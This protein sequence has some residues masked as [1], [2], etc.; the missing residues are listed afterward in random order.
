VPAER[1]LKG[2]S[3]AVANVT[4]LLAKLLC[5]ILIAVYA[6][7]QRFAILG[8][9][10]GEEQPGVYEAVWREIARQKPE[11]IIGV[12]D[13][14]QGLDDSKAAS[15]WRE[16][17][18]LV[19]PYRR[20]PLYLAPGNHDIW[21]EASEKLYQ[22]ESGRPLHYSFDRGQVHVTIL[23]DSRSEAMPQSEMTF[24][25]ED[26]HAHASRTAEGDRFASAVVACRCGAGKHQR[27]AAST[28]EAL[29]REVCYCR[30]RPST[31]SRVAGGRGI[32]FGCEF[33]R[34]SAA[35]KE[36]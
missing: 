15:E 31:D 17:Q 27:S 10:T 30:P 33:G 18:K 21:S 12:G 28:R 16:W 1:N 9:R 19:A 3:F 23:D 26:L 35:L 7:A 6:H 5:L 14:I 2:V 34:S 24:L 20:I 36:I 13:S 11:F 29:R 32:C 8:D 4:G 22:Q 25:E